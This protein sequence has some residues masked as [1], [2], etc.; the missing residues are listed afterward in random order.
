MIC[1][2]KFTKGHNSVKKMS[3]ELQYFFCA[4]WLIMLYIYVKFCQRISKVSELQTPT[5]GS[6][7]WSGKC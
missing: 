3:V 1:I 2:L 4:H 5:V 7:L 6:T